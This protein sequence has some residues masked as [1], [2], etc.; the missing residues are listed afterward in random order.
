[1]DAQP[2]KVLVWNVRGLNTP[3][4]R[5]TISQVVAAGKPSLVCFQESKMEHVTP[6]LVRHC[7]G[8]KFENFFYLPAVGTRGGIILAWD[9]T[10]VSLSNPHRT[11]NTIMALVKTLGGLQWWITGVY[12]LQLDVDKIR[13]MEELCEIRDLHAGPWAVV[14]DFNLLL[15]PEDKNNRVVNRRMMTRFRTTL[16][17]LELMGMYINGRHYTWSNER[18]CATLEKIDH[19]LTTNDWDDMHPSSFLTA[20]GMAISDHCPLLLD[21]NAD[22]K[23]GRRFRFEAFWPRAAG[24]ME[25]VTATWHSVPSTGNPY[26]VL[27]KKLRAMAKS[28]QRW[29]DKWIGN[30][31]LQIG[32]AM[33]I[34]YRLDAASDTRQLTA[35]EMG[36]RNL[37]KRKLL[38]LCSL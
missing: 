16:N 20:M 29:S 36:L 24:F 17:R 4:R 22:W 15:N 3:A 23:V 33:E 12:G 10:V 13:F 25:T 9:A 7:M 8:N 14:G 34:I 26:V 2:L 1:M 5:T 21:L 11:E 28:L 35:A 32:I 19:V 6:E 27:D 31:S 37:L 18:E 30:I 38:G